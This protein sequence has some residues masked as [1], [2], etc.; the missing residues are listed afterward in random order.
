[1]IPWP[2]S[3]VGRTTL[4]LIVGVAMSNLA[5]IAFFFHE[6]RDALMAVQAHR[7][8]G[9][10]ASVIEQLEQTP[11]AQRYRLVH[12]QWRPGLRMQVTGAP[13]VD[14]SDDDKPLLVLRRALTDALPAPHT[15]GMRLMIRAGGS[16]AAMASEGHGRPSAGWR[17]GAVGVVVSLPLT[18]GSWLNTTAVLPPDPPFRLV[19]ALPAMLATTALVLAVALW[20]VRR[21]VRPWSTFAAAAER[22]GL[23]LDAEPLPEE[24]PS[25]IRHAARAF[26]RM[27][28][29]LTGFVRDRTQMLAAISH[30]L[31][32]PLTRLRLR[33]EFVDDTEE[34]RKMLA[35][36]DD[37][38]AMIAA[39]LAFARDDAAGE[40]PVALDLARVL[41]DV[42][43]EWP[44][45]GVVAYAGAERA[46]YS[47]RPVALKR[48]FRNLID[49]AVRYGGV[50][51]VTL[52]VV[53]GGVRVTVDDEGPG[54]PD[55]DL[56][57][58][59][60]PFRRGDSSRSVETGGVGLGL[61]VVRS[62]IRRHGGEVTLSNRPSGGLRASVLLPARQGGIA[63]DPQPSHDGTAADVDR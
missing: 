40:A 1:M 21:A 48:A 23:D 62:V 7:I 59:F 35:D 43:R 54:L 42:C 30:D 17:R 50:A 53:D 44:R 24:G 27:Q 12:S 51:R 20:A 4:I 13:R 29:R 32:T 47:G 25:E 31:R 19:P 38:Q 56:E 37:M 39:T 3:L 52:T 63:P 34:Q 8:A 5:V 60:E 57:R 46:P 16:R 2:R 61:A 33:A 55:A 22:L 18:D 9:E 45:P 49:N 15:R 6:R 36:L 14:A 10:L 11:P 58:L 26:N 28:G 41:D